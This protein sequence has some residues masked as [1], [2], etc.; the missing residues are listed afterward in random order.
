MENKVK[1]NLL[2]AFNDKK[3]VDAKAFGAK[4]RTKREIYK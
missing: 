3:K 4:F 1:E 2:V